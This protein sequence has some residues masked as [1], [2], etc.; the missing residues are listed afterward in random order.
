[1][2]HDH[3]F[4][5]LPGPRFASFLPSH[6]TINVACGLRLQTRQDTG[7]SDFSTLFLRRLSVWG[8]ELPCRDTDIFSS[9]WNPFEKLSRSGHEE[10]SIETPFSWGICDPSTNEVLVS[11]GA[12]RDSARSH[13]GSIQFDMLFQTHR[14][15]QTL[16]VPI[17]EHLTTYKKK[18]R[19]Q[20]Q[21]HLTSYKK[22]SER[23]IKSVLQVRRRS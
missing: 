13:C 3:P 8:G 7:S 4:Q 11:G 20:H 9:C 23:S 16:P 5:L 17:P 10:E 2:F 1:M 18:F 21:E 6:G 15:I 12:R 14:L 22:N 19:A